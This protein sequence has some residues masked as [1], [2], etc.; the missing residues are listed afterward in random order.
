MVAAVSEEPRPSR[1]RLVQFAI[2]LPESAIG[3][4]ERMA[5]EKNIAAGYEKHTKSDVGRDIILDAV[6]RWKAAADR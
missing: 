5:A 4:L 3:D 6:A 1:K 2:R